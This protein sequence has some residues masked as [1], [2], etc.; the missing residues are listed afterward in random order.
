[1]RTRTAAS[2]ASRT[3][4]RRMRKSKWSQKSPCFRTASGP[5]PVK[6][7]KEAKDGGAAEEKKEPV[8]KTAKKPAA[9][10][11]AKAGKV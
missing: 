8:K 3:S 4:I 5:E 7:E 11:S 1:M 9:K 2:S 10:K 6:E